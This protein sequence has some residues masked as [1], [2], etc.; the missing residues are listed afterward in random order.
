MKNI[1]EFNKFK[2]LNEINAD[3]QSD[4]PFVN[5]KGNFAGAENTLVGSAVINIFSFFKRKINEGILYVYVRNIYKQYASGV[6]KYA[7]K[8][9]IKVEN[10]N[11]I[12]KQI[13]DEKGN[14][15]S[16][17]KEIKV[18]FINENQSLISPLVEGS[19]V[20]YYDSKEPIPNGTYYVI[21]ENINIIVI[22]GIIKIIE[23]TEKDVK[24]PTETIDGE[25]STEKPE[26]IINDTTDT[27]DVDNEFN[28]TIKDIENK[29]NNLI[30]KIKGENKNVDKKI[31]KRMK[32]EIE[33]II[34]DININAI[35][36]IE[37]TLRSNINNSQR[38]ELEMYKNNYEK[39]LNI[40]NKLNKSIEEILKEKPIKE[41]GEEVGEESIKIKEEEKEKKE[42]K[43]TT[44]N[45]DSYEYITEEKSGKDFFGFKGVPLIGINKKLASEIGNID[46]GMLKNKNFANKFE[47]PEI[48]QGATD[49][50][51]QNKE[52][53]IKSQIAAERIYKIGE[54]TKSAAKLENTWKKQVNGVKSAF[55]RYLNVDQIDPIILANNYSDIDKLR[56]KENNSPYSLSNVTQNGAN[57]FQLL[58]NDKLG[59]SSGFPDDGLYGIMSTSLTKP[60][61]SL[62]FRSERINNTNW[63]YKILGVVNTEKLLK[64]E[65]SSDI[66]NHI[67]YEKLKISRLLG[68]EYEVKNQGCDGKYKFT[69]IIPA[70]ESSRNATISDISNKVGILSLYIDENKANK[71]GGLKDSGDHKT[72]FFMYKNKDNKPVVLYNLKSSQIEKLKITVVNKIKA[73]HSKYYIISNKGLTYYN[74]SDL[75]HLSSI[76]NFIKINKNKK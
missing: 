73:T 9:N 68:F 29:V 44:E 75:N 76:N 33:N 36:D 70:K 72:H 52:N 22:D 4:S 64:V 45:Y 20:V 55:N 57:T 5:V 30:K 60:P 58:D 10:D 18:H 28:E 65:N 17:E 3:K 51:L 26:K 47:S 54:N 35:P 8:N 74:P 23:Y 53:I 25:E 59:L 42:E 49:I 34:K 67:E 50:V 71:E 24:T 1:T 12:I 56:E 43:L 27:A 16:E 63:V 7:V 61:Y 48:R 11:Y 6:L 19:K 32:N 14:K 41:V 46:M 40:L 37:K 38:I 66:Q 31:L 62:L 15:I 2:K 21:N 69:Y 39:E 13:K